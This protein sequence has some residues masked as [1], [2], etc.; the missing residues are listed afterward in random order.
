MWAELL[1]CSKLCKSS[2]TLLED[3]KTCLEDFRRDIGSDEAINEP[4]KLLLFCQ[5]TDAVEKVVVAIKCVDACAGLAA[6][7]DQS[8]LG[9]LTR[10]VELAVESVSKFAEPALEMIAGTLRGSAQSI[11]GGVTSVCGAGIL[12]SC[13]HLARACKAGQGDHVIKFTVNGWA[14]M[15]EHVMDAGS[16]A[17]HD[18]CAL[19]EQVQAAQSN[20]TVDTFTQACNLIHKVQTSRDLQFFTETVRDGAH[21]PAILKSL[22]EAMSKA[23]VAHVGEPVAWFRALVQE[24]KHVTL[25]QL[26]A[27]NRTRM[28]TAVERHIRCMQKIEHCKVPPEDGSGKIYSSTWMS[29]ELAHEGLAAVSDLVSFS[30]EEGNTEFPGLQDALAALGKRLNDTLTNVAKSLTDGKKELSTVHADAL[31][32]QKCLEENPDSLATDVFTDEVCAIVKKYDSDATTDGSDAPIAMAISSAASLNPMEELASLLSGRKD[33]CQGVIDDTAA[34]ALSVATEQEPGSKAFKQTLFSF[35]TAE[36]LLRDRSDTAQITKD[37][38]GLIRFGNSSLG[39]TKK[40][41]PTIASSKLEKL[42]KDHQ[43]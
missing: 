7:S 16:K 41:L 2:Q 40:E 28:G 13:W 9:A 15:P 22:G 20:L 10:E 21:S 36:L 43:N 27:A 31:I 39:L 30:K 35:L 25:L 19:A 8:D 33:D 11:P 6:N 17:L 37:S 32:V 42:S 1:A 26:S 34:L 29:K 3:C 24:G 23:A 5:K 18:V 14:T 12:K 4:L 38:T